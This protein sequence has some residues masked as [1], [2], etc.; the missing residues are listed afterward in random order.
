MSFLHSHYL[1]YRNHSNGSGWH[2]KAQPGPVSLVSVCFQPYLPLAPPA[3]G[4][5]PNCLWSRHHNASLSVFVR[6]RMRFALSP[7]LWRAVQCCEAFKTEV[8][9]FPAAGRRAG[10]TDKPVGA[11]ADRSRLSAVLAALPLPLPLP[12]PQSERIGGTVYDRLWRRC[13]SKIARAKK[14]PLI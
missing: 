2:K 13:L 11:N 5:T 9:L 1:R 14:F 3:G 4:N 6:L 7:C 8:S 12:G 10:C